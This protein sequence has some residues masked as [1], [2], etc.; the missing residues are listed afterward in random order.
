MDIKIRDV[1]PMTVKKLDEWAKEK[2]MS[3][4]RYL[5]EMLETIAVNDIHFNMLDRYEEQLKANTLLLEKTSD[6]VNE[7]VDVMK[8]LIV[9]E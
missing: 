2:G 6:A 8:E 1:H 9:D 7:L 4:Q 3:R 5:K